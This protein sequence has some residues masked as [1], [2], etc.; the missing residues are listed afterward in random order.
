MLACPFNIPKYE[1]NRITPKVQKCNFCFERIKN[2]KQ[3]ACTEACQFDA[4]IF[5]NY[6]DILK[7]AQNRIKVNPDLY[8]QRIYGLNEA[9]GTSVF[10]ISD[11]SFDDIGVNTRIDLSPLPEL[12]WSYISKI[13]YV[14]L[15]GGPFLY[16][17]HWII[18]RR[19]KLSER[20]INDVNK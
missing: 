20:K 18:K 19:I 2:E 3:P 9:G 12:S 17:I 11:I 16:G 1:W 10:Y 4:T 5:G 6:H 15:V 14:V 13:P 8:I 7:E